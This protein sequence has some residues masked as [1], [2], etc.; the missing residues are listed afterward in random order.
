VSSVVVLGIGN[1][2]M[3]DEG[4]GVR[5]AEALLELAPPGVRVVVAGSL[6]PSTL[7]QV[8]DASRLLVL[9][10]IEAGLAPG[11][12]V[13]CDPSDLPPRPSSLSPHEFGVTDLLALL[14]QTAVLPERTVVLGIEPARIEPGIGLSPDVAAAIPRLVDAALAVLG[15][16]T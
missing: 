13:R 2:L 15:A 7:P 3:R 14:A 16:W 4:L 6:G 11:A 1:I 12:V 8:E 9:D 5:A 10:A